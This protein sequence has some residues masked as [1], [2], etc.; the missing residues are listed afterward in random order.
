MPVQEETR[1]SSDAAARAP[2]VTSSLIAVPDSLHLHAVKNP[3]KQENV[4]RWNTYNLGLRAG[5]DAASAIAAGFLVAP[6]VCT[7]DRYGIELCFWAFSDSMNRSIIEK[8]ATNTT[9]RSCFLRAVRPA[10][11]RPH[12]FLVSKPFLLVFTLYFS[13]YFVANGIDTMNSTLQAKPA[14]KVTAGASK[15]VATSAT[16]MSICIYK[17]SQFVKMFG[18]PKSPAATIPMLSY[19]LFA[20]RDSM[21]IFASFNLPPVIAPKLL[22]LPPSVQKQFSGILSTETRRNNTAQFFAPAAM[23]LISTPIH[24]L[25]L[26]LYNRQGDISMARRLA[27]VTR[28]WGVSALARMCRII[29]AY[30]VGGVVNTNMRKSLMKKLE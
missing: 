17:D 8:A 10:I 1:R 23:Q 5:A 7:I 2:A 11:A 4:S 6:V 29:P 16:N 13:T 9:F 3:L 19:A 22:D 28:D 27:R 25:G 21:T 15:F 14:S 24:L 20:M 26:D 12:A 18:K 30:G